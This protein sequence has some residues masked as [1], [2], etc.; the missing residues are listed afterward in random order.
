MGCDA[1]NVIKQKQTV[2]DRVLVDQTR[3]GAM[4]QHVIKQTVL[5][6]RVLVDQTRW[7]LQHVIKQTVTATCYQ[8]DSDRV[9][10]DQT[11]WGAMLHV[12]DQTRWGAML[13]H[14]TTCYQTDSRSQ[15]T[16]RSNPM[17]CDVIKQTVT[18]CYQT[19]SD[20][21]LVDQTRWGAN[22]TTC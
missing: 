13:Q 8:T 22:A 1:T 9:L 11:R 20:R 6:D 18:T 3:W 16:S 4:L 7:M 21:V 14:V 12:I 2:S 19:D 17:G 10:V 5:V 15:G